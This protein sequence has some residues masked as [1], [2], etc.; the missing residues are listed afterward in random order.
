MKDE[1]TGDK[2]KIATVFIPKVGLLR[3]AAPS[4]VQTFA[5]ST[6]TSFLVKS[7]GRLVLGSPQP[8]STPAG[9]FVLRK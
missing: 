7:T 5:A 4:P 2:T 8:D 1:K 3:C 9:G 6:N